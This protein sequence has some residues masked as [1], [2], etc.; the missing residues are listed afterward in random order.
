[1]I[2]KLIFEY[3]FIDEHYY[4][5]SRQKNG[6]MNGEQKVQTLITRFENILFSKSVLENVGF[7][8]SVAIDFFMVL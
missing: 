4:C 8:R 2:T 6:A 3:I 7:R 1:M 5:F